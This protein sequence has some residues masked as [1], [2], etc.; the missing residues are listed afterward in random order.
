ML[1]S[2]DGATQTVHL[3][4]YILRADETGRRVLSCLEARAAEGVSVR[5]IFDSVGSHGLDRRALDGLERAGASIAEFNPP[6]QWL[7]RFRPRQRDH[8]KIQL[9]DGRVGFLV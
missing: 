6:S 3:E 5:L 7:W 8:R 1:E 2:I 4:T 9:V